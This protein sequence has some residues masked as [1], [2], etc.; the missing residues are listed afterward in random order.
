MKSE[1]FEINAGGGV[2][3]HC[4]SWEPDNTPVAVL[5]VVHGLGEHAGRYEEMAKIFTERQV[6]VFGYDHR[7]HGRSGGRRGH[8]AS[9]D[10]L[11]EDLEL[12]LMKCRSLHL[13][14]PLFM[15]GHSMGGQIAATYINRVKSKEL[16]GA[17]ISSAW[18]A[19]VSPPPAWQV[20]VIKI[21]AR[22]TPGL[23][24]SN[25]LDPSLISRVPEEVERYKSDELVHDRISIGLFNELYFNGLHLKDHAQPARISMLV[26]H[27][28][29]DG[30]TAPEA[31]R[32]YAERL[33]GK[34]EFKIWEGA[35]HEPHNDHEKKQVMNFYAGWVLEKLSG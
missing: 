28:G 4:T 30:I 25:K 26:C 22:I 29:N 15:Y 3:L 33:G 9:L 21:L 14:A 31:S 5:F 18:F 12:A 17:I 8:A 16:S 35:Y 11:L 6:A 23:T 2:T 1:N 20:S 19:L 27:G 13:G 7:G 24:L 32:Q 10:Q 34:A